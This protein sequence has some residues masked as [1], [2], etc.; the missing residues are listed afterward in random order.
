MV[1]AIP[2]IWGGGSPRREKKSGAPLLHNRLFSA[3]IDVA[4]LLRG[5]KASA[6]HWHE[7]GERLRALEFEEELVLDLVA[8]VEGGALRFAVQVPD[9]HAAAIAARIRDA[10]GRE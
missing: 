1:R 4:A 2:G 9:A 10:L 3:R 7:R 5:T 6:Q 8:S